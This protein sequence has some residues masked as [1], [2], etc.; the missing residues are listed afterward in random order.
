MWSEEGT[1]YI[2]NIMEEKSVKVS[3]CGAPK[4]YG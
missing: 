2:G 4:D 1:S 3:Q